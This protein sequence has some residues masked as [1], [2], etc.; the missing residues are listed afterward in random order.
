MAYEMVLR[1]NQSWW[2]FDWRG[3]WS[4]RDLLWIF[5]QRDLTVVYKQSILGPLWFVLQP[6]VTTV[7]FTLIFGSMA[8][9][10]TDGIPPFLFF[11]GGTVLWNYFAGCMNSVANTLITNAA[12]F[13]KVY[14]PRL[15][16][17][18]AMVLSNLGQFLL[19][20]AIFLIFWGQ[21]LLTHKP[22]H[23]TLGLLFLPILILQTAAAGMGAGLW[24]AAM[25]VKYRDLRFALPF[26][27]QVWMFVTPI[28]YPSSVVVP[29]HHWV[30]GIN[31]MAGLVDLGRHIF[32]GTPTM[33]TEL[34]M[35]NSL[36]GVLLLITG[37]LAFNKVERTFVDT[38]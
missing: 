10:G 7:V 21:A 35:I 4:Y 15:V 33:P 12:L 20:L 34:Y 28:V 17:P 11:L 32:L 8:K 37:L 31:P 23:P 5:V 27:A 30:L 19:N 13:N 29:K 22:V 38:V 3:I 2:R 14:F 36:L 9:I 24:L 25:T 26:L 1:P 16:S 18:L 6:L